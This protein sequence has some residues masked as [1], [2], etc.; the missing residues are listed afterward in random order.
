[1]FLVLAIID[2]SKST[3]ANGVYSFKGTYHH[4]GKV[5]HKQVAILKAMW[6]A[7]LTTRF[8]WCI[9]GETDP[10]NKKKRLNQVE[11]LDVNSGAGMFGGRVG[12]AR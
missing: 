7:Q 6:Q 11:L 2:L 10:Q 12:A 8:W 9:I 4:C 3:C 5:G 1:M